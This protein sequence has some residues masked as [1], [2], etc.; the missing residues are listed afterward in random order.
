MNKLNVNKDVESVLVEVEKW[1]SD[2]DGSLFD[3]K[4][5]CELYDKTFE[6]KNFIVNEDLIKEWNPKNW[7]HFLY[8]FIQNF[9]TAYH[10]GNGIFCPF[11]V[12]YSFYVDINTSEGFLKFINKAINYKENIKTLSGKQPIGYKHNSSNGVIGIKWFFKSDMWFI[13][14]YPFD[15]LEYPKVSVSN[16]LIEN[17]GLC[18]FRP[19]DK[20]FDKFYNFI[21]ACGIKIT[22]EELGKKLRLT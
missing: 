13:D 3:Y 21:I 15:S 19:S 22:K 7:K 5:E 4:W 1:K 10:L 18:D 11:P 9:A 12:H 20:S 6:S 2:N 14:H 17:I 16:K 8:Y